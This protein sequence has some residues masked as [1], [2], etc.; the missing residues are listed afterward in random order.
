MRSSRGIKNDE[1]LL[2]DYTTPP[3][4][5]PFVPLNTAYFCYV[6]RCD[7][8]KDACGTVELKCKCISYMHQECADRWFQKRA[9]LS[10]ANLFEPKNQRI[11]FEVHCEICKGMY[12]YIKGCQCY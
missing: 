5:V 9:T 6:C 2:L 8:D 12:I 10:V 1:E 7:V 4:V 3:P 11:T